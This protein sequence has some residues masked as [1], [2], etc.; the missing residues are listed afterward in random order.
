MVEVFTIN[1]GGNRVLLPSQNLPGLFF[2]LI[3]ACV[4]LGINFLLH[5]TVTPL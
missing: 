1:G 4:D 2:V 3:R 5:I